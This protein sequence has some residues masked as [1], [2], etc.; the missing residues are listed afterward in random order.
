MSVEKLIRVALKEKGI[1][2]RKVSIKKIVYTRTIVVEIT[3]NDPEISL[4]QIKEIDFAEICK[5][6][7]YII[8]QRNPVFYNNLKYEKAV[9]NSLQELKGNNQI[10]I[11]GTGWIVFKRDVLWFFVN[12]KF[13][14]FNTGC[15]SVHENTPIS[16][17]VE[18][19]Y[20][21]NL[22]YLFLK[23]KKKI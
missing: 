13:Q 15:F 9:E 17:I 3:V 5:N 2:N 20:E 6:S 14:E 7:E 4:L 16:E 8:L 10:K 1:N 19:M 11:N 22:D 18:R 21:E 23:N 12:E